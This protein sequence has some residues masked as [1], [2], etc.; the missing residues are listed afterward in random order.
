MKATDVQ[1]TLDTLLHVEDLLMNEVDEAH[2]DMEEWAYLLNGPAPKGSTSK[3]PKCRTAACVGGYIASVTPTLALR[4]NGNRSVTIVSRVNS[5]LY[6]GTTHLLLDE[7]LPAAT[8]VEVRG[9]INSGADHQTPKAASRA[10]LKLAKEIAA[11][12]DYE[13]K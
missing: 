1:K 8:Y 5:S 10:C 7:A 12:N 11:R 4:W 6:R 2:F 9:L 13:I 3:L